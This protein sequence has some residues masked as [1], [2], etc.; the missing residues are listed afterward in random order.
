[1]MMIHLGNKDYERVADML[2][3]L[4]VD[5]KD[6]EDVCKWLKSAFEAT[7]TWITEDQR[8][9]DELFLTLTANAIRDSAIDL[10]RVSVSS[11][12]PPMFVNIFNVIDAIMD[13]RARRQ[14]GE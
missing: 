12:L 11:P 2:V 8:I 4:P 3:L 1:M 10:K 13:E 5:V 6:K 7:A 9:R 14:A